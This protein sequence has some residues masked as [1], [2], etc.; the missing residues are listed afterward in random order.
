MGGRLVADEAAGAWLAGLGDIKDLYERGYFSED[1]LT[2]GDTETTALFGEGGRGFPAGRILE[3]GVFHRALPGAAGGADG[4]LRS[5]QGDET[6]YRHHRGYLY[7][8]FHHPAGLE[9][10]GEAGSGGVLCFPADFR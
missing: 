3:G 10:P 2:A 7:R 5:G 6:G 1:T 8:V 4:M 9:R